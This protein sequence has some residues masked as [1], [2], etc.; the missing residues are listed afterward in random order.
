MPFGLDKFKIIV[1]M[2]KSDDVDTTDPE[3]VASVSAAEGIL[4][5]LQNVSGIQ[6]DKYLIDDEIISRLP[7]EFR[8][9][10]IRHRHLGAYVSALPLDE[11]GIPE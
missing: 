6:G 7:D 10:S 11:I 3:E 9:Q 8:E 1:Q 4:S 5:Y 2:N